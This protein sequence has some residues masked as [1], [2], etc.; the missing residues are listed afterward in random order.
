[1]GTWATKFYLNSIE[2]DIIKYQAIVLQGN[3]IVS[4]MFILFTTFAKHTDK[5]FG[6]DK[7]TLK[8]ARKYRKFEHLA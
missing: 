2:M 5:Q 1:M 6:S 8:E 3:C 4:I 7:F